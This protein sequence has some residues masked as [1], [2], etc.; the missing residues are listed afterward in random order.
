MMHA[1]AR[2]ENRLRGSQ[3]GSLNRLAVI[4]NWRVALAATPRAVRFAL[5]RVRWRAWR[6]C[7]SRREA[8]R[9]SSRGASGARL[10]GRVIGVASTSVVVA[11]VVAILAAALFYVIPRG[12]RPR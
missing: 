1:I 11:I 12:R 7:R 4:L 10:A 8:T 3:P 6:G 2:S 5:A 9:S